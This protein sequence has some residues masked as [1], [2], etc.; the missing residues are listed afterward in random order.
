MLYDTYD[1]HFDVENI[2]NVIHIRLNNIS[3]LYIFVYMLVNFIY[4]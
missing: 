2:F 3:N 1:N 4:S